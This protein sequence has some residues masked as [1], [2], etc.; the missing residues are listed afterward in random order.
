MLTEFKDILNNPI[1]L[2][3]TVIT[4]DGTG[5]SIGRASHLSTAGNLMLKVQA[6]TNG[7][8]YQRTMGKF[9]C[10]YKVA[11]TKDPAHLHATKDIKIKGEK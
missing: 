5:I 10:A 4:Q 2:G 7:Y 6:S 11:I 9:Y 8:I 3:D 1:K